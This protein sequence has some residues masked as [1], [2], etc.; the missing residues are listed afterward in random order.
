M[1]G[2]RDR[3]TRSSP[4]TMK[5]PKLSPVQHSHVPDTKT[6]PPCL[7]PSNRSYQ[8][9]RPTHRLGARQA[10]GPISVTKK[11]NDGASNPGTPRQRGRRRPTRTTP[12][13]SGRCGI[14][15]G[16]EGH[17]RQDDTST[18]GRL[19]SRRAQGHT[20][21]ERTRRVGPHTYSTATP[22]ER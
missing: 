20:H 5:A 21:R 16:Q 4:I 22:S 19:T 12:H 8:P 6:G 15:G 17:I 11:G 18:L 14:N 10:G 7:T 2:P 13:P 3:K 9:E 1:Q